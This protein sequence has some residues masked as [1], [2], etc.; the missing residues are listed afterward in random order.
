MKH[1]FLLILFVFPVGMLYGQ[2]KG[3]CSS[4]SIDSVHVR[5]ESLYEDFLDVSFVSDKHTLSLFK[6]EITP[7][8][9]KL[10]YRT[11]NYDTIDYLFSRIR[12]IMNNPPIWDSNI[13]IYDCCPSINISSYCQG[14][15]WKQTYVLYAEAYFPFAYAELYSLIRY[16]IVKYVKKD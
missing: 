15:V 7:S 8:P 5:F 4:N 13:V 10:V 14:N 11:N 1:L 2:N 12:I 9:N 6:T 16:Y 3:N